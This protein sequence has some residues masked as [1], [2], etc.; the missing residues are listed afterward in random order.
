MKNQLVVILKSVFFTLMLITFTACSSKE[1]YESIQP[2]YD[3]NECRKRPPH[4][5]DECMKHETKSYEE[6][7]KE[8]EEVI[9]QD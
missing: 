1:L 5:Y 6:Y 7:I 8:K 3:E 9:N 4:Q 2:K